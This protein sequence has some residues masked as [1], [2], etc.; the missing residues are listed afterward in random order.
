MKPLRGRIL[1]FT[2]VVT[3][4]VSAASAQ[5]Y[6]REFGSSRSSSGIGRLTPGAEVFEGNDPD[7][8]SPIDSID[9]MAESTQEED[10]NFRLGNVDFVVAAG[11]GI[12]FNDNINLG[13]RDRLSDLIF[14]P[15]LDIEG[16]WRISD[17]N[18]LRF[19]LGL[20]YAKYLEHSE[21]DSDSLLIAPNSAIAWTFKSG[22]FT[23]TLRERLSYQEDPFDLP[24][25]SNVA[26]YARWE[27]QAGIQ[28]DW[29]AN[30]LTRV[31]FGYDRYD[32][33]AKEEFFKSQDRGI[34]TVYLRPSYQINPYFTV[35]LNMAV[36]WVDFR[37][38][39]Q[40][41]A[42]VYMIGPYILWKVNDTFDVYTEVGY[43]M[44]D[45]D[46]GT[47][48]FFIDEDGEMVTSGVAVDDE[49]ASNVY[50][51]LELR[52]RPSENFR[53]KLMASKTTEVGFGSNFY[54]L[55]HIE[56]TADWKIGENTSLSPTI[57]YEYYETSGDLQE[58]AY[59]FG[60]AIG[61]H[62]ILSEHFTV[63]LDYRFLLKDSDQ[64]D[65]D[66]YQNLALLS[67]YYKF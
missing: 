56:Y 35:G 57:F 21:Y 13:D 48:E 7:G 11:I 12:E 18:K 28:V 25:A 52:H 10:Y 3:L 17:T 30:E 59:R 67:L 36:S 62:H 53:H 20:S 65:S 39:I 31:T 40:A 1:P 34:D 33:W 4:L 60:A 47:Q 27:N 15:S 42:L 50:V 58:T 16:V 29:D 22:A 45:F 41:D 19:G 54:D 8:L 14:R 32:L 63:G 55:Y 44:S 37:E 38:N 51:K 26:Q 23:I 61:I 24:V 2:S 5:E 66:Y 46:G 9:P 49:D 64:P 43:Q 6:F